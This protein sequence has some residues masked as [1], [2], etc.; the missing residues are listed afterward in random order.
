MRDEHEIVADIRHAEDWGFLDEI[1]T[2]EAELESVRDAHRQQGDLVVAANDQA[3]AEWLADRDER[4]AQVERVIEAEL[5]A[6][7]ELEYLE[8]REHQRPAAWL[9]QGGPDERR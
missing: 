8:A 5:A 9:A 6:I 2:L 7:R 1:P 4:E 3:V